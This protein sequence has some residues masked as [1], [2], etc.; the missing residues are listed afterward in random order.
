MTEKAPKEWKGP[1]T[2]F[3]RWPEG[4]YIRSLQQRG[5]KE[6]KKKGGHLDTKQLRGENLRALRSKKEKLIKGGWGTKRYG[7][8]RN[9]SSSKTTKWNKRGL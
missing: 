8:Q 9:S 1:E 4:G 7:V 3:A 5:G 6:N 2:L